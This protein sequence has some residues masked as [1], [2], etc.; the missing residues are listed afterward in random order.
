MEGKHPTCKWLGDGFYSTGLLQSARVE[1]LRSKPWASLVFSPLQYPY[2]EGLW[3]GPLMVLVDQGT[4]SAAEQFAAELQDNH[5]AVVIG[6]PTVGAG[7]GHTDG[8][9]P[10]TLTNSGAVLKLPDCLRMR[11]A[12]LNLASGVQPDVLVGLREGERESSGSQLANKLPEHCGW[13]P[14]RSGRTRR[15]LSHPKL[16]SHAK[17]HGNALYSQ[18]R[19]S[20]I[21]IG[22][23]AEATI[24]AIAAQ[25]PHLACN[26]GMCSKFI[27]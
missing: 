6:S 5:A 14:A 2:H 8:G 1:A 20:E 27:P 9:T 13:R 25:A 21:R 10:T 12:G 11:S 7:C 23:S 4:G 3:R 19:P 26:Q 15:P 18:P 22:H 17:P 24:R 16:G